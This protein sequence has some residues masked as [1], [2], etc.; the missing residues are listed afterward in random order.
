MAAPKPTS[1]LDMDNPETDT[2]Q[3]F[4]ALGEAQQEQKGQ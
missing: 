2:R 1:A 4:E 3:A